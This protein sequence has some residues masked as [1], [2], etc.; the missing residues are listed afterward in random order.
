LKRDSFGQSRHRNLLK[1]K[2]E[3]VEPG[4]HADG[5]DRKVANHGVVDLICK[6]KKG[7]GPEGSE[8]LPSQTIAMTADGAEIILYVDNGEADQRWPLI[9]RCG[10]RYEIRSKLSGKLFDVKWRRSIAA[11]FSSKRSRAA[12]TVRKG[13]WNPRTEYFEQC[14]SKRRLC[15]LAETATKTGL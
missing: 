5:G 11:K 3:A 14:L 10:G 4:L 2:A 1:A 7:D 15:G 13:H 8:A 12:E 9:D 6:K